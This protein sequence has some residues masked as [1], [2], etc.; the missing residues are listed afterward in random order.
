MAAHSPL[1]MKRT[2]YPPLTTQPSPLSKGLPSNIAPPYI[3]E[4]DKLCSEYILKKK[5]KKRRRREMPKL[6]DWGNR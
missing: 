3:F 5:K 1:T 6:I 4:M 2:T